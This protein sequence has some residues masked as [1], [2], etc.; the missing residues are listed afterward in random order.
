MTIRPRLLRPGGL[1][2]RAIEAVLGHPLAEAANGPLHGP[3][4]LE[5]HYAP[6]ARLRLNVT[7]PERDETYLGFG[8]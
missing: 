8:P 1:S 4:K 5:S 2:R 3:G 6:K 7:T